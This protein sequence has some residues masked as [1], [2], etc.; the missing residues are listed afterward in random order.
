M[1]FKKHWAKRDYYKNVFSYNYRYF[2]LIT[3]PEKYKSVR[4]YLEFKY[5]KFQYHCLAAGITQRF[6]IFNLKTFKIVVSMYYSGWTSKGKAAI[7]FRQRV[8][9]EHYQHI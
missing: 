1:F 5:F 8:Y 3:I 7:A 6:Y 4:N 2:K 9:E